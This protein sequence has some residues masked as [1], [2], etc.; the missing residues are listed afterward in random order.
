MMHDRDTRW[1]RLLLTGLGAVLLGAGGCGSRLW[2]IDLPSG[3]RRAQKERKL[4]LIEFTQI[5][6]V[7]TGR[8]H[9]EAFTDPDVTRLFQDFVPVRLDKITHA[10]EAQRWGLTRT[11]TYLIA[12]PD[13]TLVSRFDG[14][15]SAD[16]FRRFLIRARISQ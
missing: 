3:L 12:R 4:V 2:S 7:H 9:R 8:M 1:R 6:C 5:G 16:A 13:G 14:A 15:M 10:A 11:P